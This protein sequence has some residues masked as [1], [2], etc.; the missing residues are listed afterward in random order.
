MRLRAPNT[1]LCL[2][3]GI[4]TYCIKFGKLKHGLCPVGGDRVLFLHLFPLFKS[5]LKV[6]PRA[7]L[8]FLS[9][10]A[11]TEDAQSRQ[12]WQMFFREPAFVA[13]PSTCCCHRVSG[14]AHQNLAWVSSTGRSGA[15]GRISGARSGLWSGWSKSETRGCRPAAEEKTQAEGSPAGY[16]G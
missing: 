12:R 4:T 2:C 6:C 14:A 5:T 8:V 11:M 13:L 1:P 9:P 3:L 7:R 16:N 15:W 10:G